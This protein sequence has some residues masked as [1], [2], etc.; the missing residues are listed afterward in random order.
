[1][2]TGKRK[3][4]KGD[5]MVSMTGI[6]S[7][8]AVSPV[9]GRRCLRP[10]P[11]DLQNGAAPSHPRGILHEHHFCQRCHLLNSP[12]KPLV[13]IRELKQLQLYI[14]KHPDHSK[15]YSKLKKG[16]WEIFFDTFFYQKI[17]SQSAQQSK[18][19]VCH[20]WWCQRAVKQFNF[21]I[22][23]RTFSSELCLEK[24]VMGAMLKSQNTSCTD[25]P[26]T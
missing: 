11:R 24:I 8:S 26:R 15:L 17:S 20:P 14:W 2:L 6:V 9:G 21:W 7:F 22:F 18:K 13:K 25:V 1:M 10:L 3:H 16:S 5:K 19:Q 4:C 23:I 12:T